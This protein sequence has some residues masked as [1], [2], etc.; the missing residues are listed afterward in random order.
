M[1]LIFKWYLPI[2]NQYFNTYWYLTDIYRYLEETLILKV[3]SSFHKLE[4]FKNFMEEIN[5]LFFPYFH[6]ED[7]YC[8]TELFEC[9][10]IF[11]FC[12]NIFIFLNINTNLTSSK[13][14]VLWEAATYFGRSFWKVSWKPMSRS[15]LSDL[16]LYR[17]FWGFWSHFFDLL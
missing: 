7:I 4:V 14:W 12:Q 15:K 8:C 6:Y 5:S 11:K 9:T 1:K 13:I 17:R 2:F 3:A 10:F 16:E